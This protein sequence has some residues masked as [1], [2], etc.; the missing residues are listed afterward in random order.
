MHTAA[1]AFIAIA[2]GSLTDILTDPGRPVLADKVLMLALP[3]KVL[4]SAMLASITRVLY[5]RRLAEARR[6]PSL[7][8]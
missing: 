4:A 7:L 6:Q 1:V 8:S 2:A 3:A 5:V